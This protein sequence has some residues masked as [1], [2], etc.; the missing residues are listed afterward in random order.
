MVDIALGLFIIDAIQ[1]LAV[2]DRA[3]SRNGEHLGLTTGKHTGAVYAGQQS[4]FGSQRADFVHA[5]AV[6]ALLLV[7]QPAAHD[8]FL[9]AVHTV[10]DERF[11]LGV[12]GIKVLVHLLVD[13]LQA[14]VADGLVVG[15]HS[16]LDVLH[17]ELFD[18]LDH[19]LGGQVAGIF[20][21]GLADFGLNAL[22]EFNDVL[23]GLVTGDNAVV[24][25]LVGNLVGACFDHGNTGIGGGN[26][27]G[28]LG[29]LALLGVGVDDKLAVNEAHAHSG[30]GS[31]PRHV[32][33]GQSDGSTHHSGD[34][35][36]AVRVHGHDGADDGNIV[37]HILGEQRT[38]GAV[39][40]A[41]HQNGLVGG[42][43]FPLQEGAGDLAHGIQ[44][45]LK[46]HGQREEINALTGLCS[47]G[48]RHMHHGLAIADQA[49]A[50]GQL[51][52]FAGFHN[53]RTAGKFGFIYAE[54]L[55]H[56]AFLHFFFRRRQNRFSNKTNA[57]R[58]RP[59]F[60]AKHSC[61][62]SRNNFNTSHR[63][64]R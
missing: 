11:L 59:R 9:S 34:F 60:T 44:L 56:S 5:A 35:G 64:S 15:I 19:F 1:Q 36:G 40:D 33:D 43:A 3:Q 55:E 13:G 51:C 18:G 42:T 52:H 38:D 6:H 31:V 25:I 7:Q 12:N 62:S 24:H 21:L 30:N 22:D 8:I 57:Q 10:V 58:L 48:Y 46:V 4:H 17:G 32:G 41:A 61:P 47:S 14:L 50:V 49:L 16:E 28:H 29:N 23:V 45:L 53:Q 37:A 20:K 26:G 54:F 39:D 63:G 27:D 2:A